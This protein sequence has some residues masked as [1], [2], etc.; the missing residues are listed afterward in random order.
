MSPLAHRAVSP[1]GTVV[2]LQSLNKK[3]C[4]STCFAREHDTKKGSGALDAVWPSAEGMMAVAQPLEQSP[5][6]V[7]NVPPGGRNNL[8]MLSVVAFQSV[9]AL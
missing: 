4:A 8:L 9:H 1:R 7:S 2:S 5:E 6:T 3:S